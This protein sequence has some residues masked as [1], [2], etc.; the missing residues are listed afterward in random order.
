LT[1]NIGSLRGIAAILE[2]YHPG[3]FTAYIRPLADGEVEARHNREYT[4]KE[5]ERLL[6]NSGFTVTL[7][8]T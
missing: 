8:E 7:I 1:P 6:A 4:P 3:I 2:G 5:I